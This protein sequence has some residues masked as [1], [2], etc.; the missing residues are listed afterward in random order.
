MFKEGLSL[1]LGVNYLLA[2]WLWA[3]ESKFSHRVV[4]IIKCMWLCFKH[5]KNINYLNSW[6]WQ[7]VVFLPGFALMYKSHLPLLL[8]RVPSYSLITFPLRYH[9]LDT[10][11]ERCHEIE[12]RKN[13]GLEAGNLALF[14]IYSWLPWV[15]RWPVWNSVSLSET[16]GSYNCLDSS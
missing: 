15:R 13:A 10:L 11:A 7:A 9:S 2:L 3:R 8:S 6:R 16:E 1:S 12:E 5:S 14:C 4:G